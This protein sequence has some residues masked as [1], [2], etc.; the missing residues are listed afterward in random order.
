MPVITM[1]LDDELV[2]RL[3]AAAG[4][5][6]RSEFIRGLIEAALS[7]SASRSD[8]DLYMAGV[9]GLGGRPTERQVEQALGWSGLRASR[10]LRRL[11]SR[12]DVRMVSGGIEVIE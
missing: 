8:D 5:G 2:E 3:D 11:I 9:V 12:G 7:S 4:R 6:G 1:R 10:A